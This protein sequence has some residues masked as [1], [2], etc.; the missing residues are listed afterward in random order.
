M[1]GGLPIKTTQPFSPPQDWI[2][3]V[4]RLSKLSKISAGF[5]SGLIAQESAF[6]SFALSSSRALGLT[7][8]TPAADR[9]IASLHPE[10]PRSEKVENLPYP[11]LKALVAS[12]QLSGNEDWRLDPQL[13][14]EGGAAYLNF[15]ENYWKL[16]AKTVSLREAGDAELQPALVLA[17]YHSGASRVLKALQTYGPDF[18]NAPELK[19]A[20]RYVRRVSS[21]CSYF[22]NEAG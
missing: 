10:W 13:S 19:A 2:D 3:S 1:F 9:E 14:I 17:S 22:T 16:K 18:I 5:L 4:E 8:V 20:K 11:I 12:R 7:Q 6:N 15:L 21:Y